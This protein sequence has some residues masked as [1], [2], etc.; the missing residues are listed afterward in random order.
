[1]SDTQIQKPDIWWWKNP[2]SLKELKTVIWNK[3]PEWF[4]TKTG[5]LIGFY[6]TLVIIQGKLM[7]S[8]KFGFKTG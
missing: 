3:F 4:G 1:M 6:D 7:F 5:E 2:K 8:R